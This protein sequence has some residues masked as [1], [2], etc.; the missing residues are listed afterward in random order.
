MCCILLL[1]CISLSAASPSADSLM[2][3]SDSTLYHSKAAFIHQVGAE[4]RPG[5]IFQTNDFLRGN[6]VPGKKH[7]FCYSAHLRYAVQYN[8][9]TLIDRIFRGTYQGVGVNYYNFGD[10]KRM[11]NPWSAYIFQGGEIARLAPTVSFNYEWNLGL[12]WNW[13]HY[14]A[15]TN[16]NNVVIGSKL[17]A[18][19]NA[20]LFLR[21]MLSR[22]FDLVTGVDLTHF[23]NGNTQ[24]PNAGLNL[25]DFK[26]GLIYN[27][28]RNENQQ[29]AAHYTEPFPTFK[30]HI[31]YDLLFF[32]S[33]RRKGVVF[34]DAKVAS[35]YKYNVWGFSFAPMY[36]LCY[37]FRTGISLD[38]AYDTSANVKAYD[39]SGD[40][41]AGKHP[42]FISPAANEQMALGLSARAEYVMPF[43]SINLGVGVNVLHKGGD[44][45]SV[46]EMLSLKAEVTRNIYLHVGY[47]LQ[48]FH[49]PNYL[50]LGIGLRFNNKTSRIYR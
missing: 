43:F 48:D 49:M 36:N 1:F 40:A 4:F 23:S 9:H 42:V 28:N 25:I 50:M 21:W 45:K 27:M 39:A 22:Q 29:S 5:A 11:G 18:Y 17:N 37:R 7:D 20:S 2:S 34:N 12:S 8:S 32:G 24:I 44:M 19:I 6:T 41:D 10:K 31:T 3:A 14:D 47:K 38:G 26:L 33:W 30:N 13:E 46:Y 16:P 35:P 15:R